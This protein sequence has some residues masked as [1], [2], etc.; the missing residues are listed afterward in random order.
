MKLWAWYGHSWY[1]A[2]EWFPWL[3]EMEAGFDLR[4]WLFGVSFGGKLY[5]LEF[6][7]LFIT[8]R[9]GL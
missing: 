4:R 7:P 5:T 6:G 9:S 8:Y 2:P 1:F 3:A